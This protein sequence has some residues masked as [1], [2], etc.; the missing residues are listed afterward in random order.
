MD[1]YKAKSAGNHITGHF[2]EYTITK[3]QRRWNNEKGGRRDLYR[4]YVTQMLSHH[5]YFRKYLH[6][7]GKTDSPYCRYEEGKEID[8]AEH[9]V[10][11]CVH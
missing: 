2:R 5:G 7:I 9:T 4:Y 8:D 3:W 11:R 10:F 6:K 1:I